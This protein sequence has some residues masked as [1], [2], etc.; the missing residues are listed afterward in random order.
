MSY[1]VTTAN[2]SLCSHG[3][4]ASVTMPN[5]RVRASGQPVVCQPTP[6]LVEACPAPAQSGGTL[7]PC[8]SASWLTGSLRVRSIGQPLLLT[9]SAGITTPNAVPARLLSAQVRAKGC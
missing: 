5:P 6:Y 4:K 7:P 2:T 8:I 1:L 3:G 9:T